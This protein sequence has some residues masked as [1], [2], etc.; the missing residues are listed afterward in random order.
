MYT[1][2]EVTTIKSVT[3]VNTSKLTVKW[4][5]VS[6]AS[7]YLVTRRKSGTEGYKEIKTVTDTSFTDTGLDAGAGYW[8]KVYAVN[9]GGKAESS[10]NSYGMTKCATPTITASGATGLTI[11]WNAAVGK[12]SYQYALY[13][14]APSESA[15]KKITTVTSTSYTDTGLQ[16]GNKY[17]YKV[18][19][20][21]K[22]SGAQATYSDESTG[23]TLS[24]PKA[25][26]IKISNQDE[27]SIGVSWEAVTYADK[28]QVYRKA[29]GESA[30]Q[31]TATVASTSYT[32]KKVES[33]K[34]YTYCVKAVNSVGNSGNSNELSLYAVLSAPSGVSCTA[35]SATSIE[36]TWNA[37]K[38]A[39][40]YLIRR[41]KDGDADYEVIA[42]Y[43]DS[44]TRTFTDTGLLPSTKYYYKVRTWTGTQLSAVS[45]Y[46]RATTSATTSQTL[47]SPLVKVQAQDTTTM[48]VSWNSVAGATKYE[49]YRRLAGESYA[50]TPTYTTTSTSIVDKNLKA[51][52][53]YWYRVYAVNSKQKSPKPNGIMCYTYPE[54]PAVNV[55]TVS[56]SSLRA[57][58]NGVKNA[59]YYILNIRKAG[60][61]AYETVTTTESTSYVVGSLEAGTTY[62]FRVYA[63]ITDRESY[64]TKLTSDK[65]AG[66]GGTT[67]YNPATCAH[68]YGTWT[69]T[70]QATCTENGSRYHVC[71]KCNNKE[72]VQINAT[73]HNYA[74]TWTIIQNATCEE[75]GAK[76]HVCQTCGEQSDITVIAAKGHNYGNTWVTEKETSCETSGIKYRQC[77]ACADKDYE[78]IPATGHH[79]EVAKRVEP[80]VDTDGY[81]EYKCENCD[82]SY[83]ELLNKLSYVEVSGVS[84]NEHDIVL[85]QLGDSKQLLA[86]VTP[87]NVTDKNVSWYIGEDSIA[88]V[89]ENGIVTA[90]SYGETVIIVE[91]EDGGFTDFCKIVVRKN[92]DSEEDISD[93]QDDTGNIQIT[94]KDEKNTEDD[95]EEGNGNAETDKESEPVCH[96]NEK[97]S[98]EQTNVITNDEGKAAPGTSY[99][100]GNVSVRTVNDDEISNNGD[101][102]NLEKNLDLASAESK[103]VGEVLF[104]SSGIFEVT[105][106][107]DE[108]EAAFTGVA[109]K[110][111]T[112]VVIPDT[113]TVDGVTYAVTAVSVDAFKNNK[114]LKKVTIGRNVEEIEK[115]A[116]SGCTSLTKVTVSAEK[117]ESIGDNA[118]AN[119]YKLTSVTIPEGVETIG[120][121][122]F[123][124]C[125]K[126]KKVIIKTKVLKK[127]GKN[128]FKGIKKKATFKCPQKQYSKYKKLLKKSKVAKTVRIK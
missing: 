61:E 89:D 24:V 110:D 25:P 16:S 108:P 30:Y 8:Y 42:A 95:K 43:V 47:E 23:S 103:D 34:K 72:T 11:K 65:P 82:E 73:G 40:G 45:D 84:L 59:S 71:S 111:I 36:V 114:K 91:T 106:T 6:G 39:D 116:F 86:D 28:Y 22:D 104:V 10:D 87:E 20:L 120:K 9:P 113:V 60:D 81:I 80:T 70:K 7:S 55:E 33:G 57:S 38:G 100:D 83:K 37:V 54:Q 50:D 35:K 122:S 102:Q 58:W 92:A 18:V 56:M 31:L 124:G 53:R 3:M 74:S 123:A 14:K 121:N 48:N 13:R 66:V 19:V 32:D 85:N 76:C 5:K 117:L 27:N 126:L 75:D 68:S 69:V 115:G 1:I 29:E 101:N 127:I 62:Y 26:V 128:A 17:S 44:N 41:R 51:G 98:E 63:V 15:F 97:D 94:D 109:N 12:T 46:G 21:E 78:S 52:T 119:C 64:I 79:F 49:I 2:P 4:S 112:K 90:V 67:K 88:S 93:N 99:N 105:V 118:F 77:S 125:K 96:V 107:G